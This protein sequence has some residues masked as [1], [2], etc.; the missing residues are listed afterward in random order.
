M[1]TPPPTSSTPTKS[2]SSISR[3]DSSLGLL[4][5]KFTSLIRS[6]LTG[7]LDLND[8]AASLNVQKRRIYD[9]TNVLEGVG[10]VTKRSKNVIAWRGQGDE[11]G[12]VKSLREEIEN[13]YEEESRL[14]YYCDR[15][16]NEV[17]SDL[18]VSF[19]DFQSGLDENQTT[20]APQQRLL[21]TSKPKTTLETR[22]SEKNYQC[23]IKSTEDV[24]VLMVGEDGLKKVD[25][26]KGENYDY[27]QGRGEGISDLF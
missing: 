11:E 15:L 8:A 20:T 26:P 13:L 5:R 19:P 22:S 6:S 23:Y 9:I 1:S 14:E 27:V 12:G 16:R 17:P 10:L 25:F 21:I 24:N 18:S 4:T 2:P 3:Y 7:S